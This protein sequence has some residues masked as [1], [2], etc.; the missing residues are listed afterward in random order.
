MRAMPK[1]LENKDWYTETYDSDGHVKYELTDAAPPDAVESYEEYY[2]EPD[3]VDE[4]GVSFV[5]DGFRIF[6]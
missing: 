1:F 5:R 3:L 2:S 6:V 4:N